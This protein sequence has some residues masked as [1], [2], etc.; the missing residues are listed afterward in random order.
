MRAAAV[1]A[2][3]W[4]GTADCTGS[5]EL[6]GAALYHA[7]RCAGRAAL[8]AAHAAAR[9]ATGTTT[10]HAYSISHTGGR[11]MALVG[12]S[13]DR[14]GIDLVRVA[15]VTARHA[16]AIVSPEEW[17][18]LGSSDVRLRP[19][20]AWAL[21]EAAAKATGAPERW[22]PDGLRILRGGSGRIEVS[23]VAHPALTFEADW[24]LDGPL[25]CAWV[26][27][28]GGPPTVCCLTTS[29]IHAAA[30]AGL[31]LGNRATRQSVT[32]R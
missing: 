6:R 18:A 4:I 10:Q 16:Q 17:R 8:A 21:K 15:R 32:T 9:E 12:R 23:L 5:A 22:F 1:A 7:D 28:R 2:G 3:C 26:I 24:H 25:L 13:N 27:R 30:R 11:G 19:A 20:L 14:L 29:F 31:C